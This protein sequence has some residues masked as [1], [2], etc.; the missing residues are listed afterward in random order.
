MNS[1][2]AFA[3]AQVSTTTRKKHPLCRETG[4]GLPKPCRYSCRQTVDANWAV[5]TR[6]C[7]VTGAYLLDVV[8]FQT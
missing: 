2:V 6:K 5:D 3:F 4:R 8:A 1:V 7:F